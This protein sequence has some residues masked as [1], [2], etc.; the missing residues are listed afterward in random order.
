MA[1]YLL[2]DI[3]DFKNLNFSEKNVQLVDN[4]SCDPSDD[5]SNAAVVVKVFVIIVV[6][7]VMFYSYFLIL[8]LCFLTLACS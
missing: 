2:F 4:T 8:F 7:G 5:I 6:L 1:T 3:C